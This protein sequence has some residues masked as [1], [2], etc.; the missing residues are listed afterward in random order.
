VRLSAA[1]NRPKAFVWL[2]IVFALGLSA[3][4]GGEFSAVTLS[5]SLLFQEPFYGILLMLFARQN[6]FSMPSPMEAIMTIAYEY[7]FFTS[8]LHL[9]YASTA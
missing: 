9:L 2:G 5:S 6:T 1:L 8:F 7:N 4:V 3:A